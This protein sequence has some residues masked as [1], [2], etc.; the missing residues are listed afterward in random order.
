[1]SILSTNFIS[2]YTKLKQDYVQF[3][4]MLYKIA[5]TRIVTGDYFLPCKLSWL[6]LDLFENFE[7]RGRQF[8]K[9][10]RNL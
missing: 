9:F 1:M 6:Y 4:S 10:V 3:Q 5:L 8:K 7:D 2:G